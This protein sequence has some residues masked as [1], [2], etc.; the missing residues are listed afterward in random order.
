MGVSAWEGISR[1]GVFPKSTDSFITDGAGNFENAFYR[2]DQQISEG[3]TPAKPI[4]HILFITPIDKGCDE[5]NKKIFAEHCYRLKNK[6]QRRVCSGLYCADYFC[7]K[8]H[9]ITFFHKNIT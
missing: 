3:K 4:A 6:I 9:S 1:C 8:F 2:T 5:N 7:L